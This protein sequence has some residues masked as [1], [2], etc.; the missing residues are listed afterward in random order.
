MFLGGIIWGVFKMLSGI[1]IAITGMLSPNKKFSFWSMLVLG[2]IYG[3]LTIYR[4]WTTDADYSG[5]IVFIVIMFNVL[6]VELTW[7]LIAGAS[8]AQRTK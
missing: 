3:V 4:S 5:K 8:F 2:I 1:L 7:A 6:V